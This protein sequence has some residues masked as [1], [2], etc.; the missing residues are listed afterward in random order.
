MNANSFFQINCIRD[1][2]EFKKFT[3]NIEYLRSFLHYHNFTKNYQEEIKSDFESFLKVF[4]YIMIMIVSLAGNIMIILVISLNKELKKS[5]NLFILNLAI[6]DLAILFSCIWVQTLLTFNKYWLLGKIFCK[7][8][9]FTQMVSIISSVLT[10]SIIS[11]DRY[12]GIIYPLKSKTR[13]KKIYYCLILLIWVFSIIFSLPTFI[14]R[15]YTERKWSDFTERYCDD[16]GW[17]IELELDDLGCF[18]K[19]SR[20]LKR[21]YYTTIVLVLFFL[22]FFIMIFTYSKIIQKLWT[23]NANGLVAST[24]KR[25]SLIRK[26]KKV[27]H[28]YDIERLNVIFKI[29]LRLL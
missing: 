25:I 13:K 7:I 23:N 3:S 15:T 19:T 6:C 11:C 2:N 21:Y 16:S 28:F 8:N 20:P 9:S 22:P 5:T 26:Q 14:F 29:I 18:S 27:I 24:D 17:P 4:F 1:M 10:L 12:I